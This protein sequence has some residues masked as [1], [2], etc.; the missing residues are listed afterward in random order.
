MRSTWVRY[1][2][3]PGRIILPN[4]HRL[5]RLKLSRPA[6]LPFERLLASR[7]GCLRTQGYPLA[8]FQD[9]GNGNFD[10]VVLLILDQGG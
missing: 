4:T 7:D 6:I 5:H 8:Q 3:P 9:F 2:R 1:G 10:F